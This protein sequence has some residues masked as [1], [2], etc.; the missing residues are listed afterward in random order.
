[1]S[2][3]KY[4]VATCHLGTAMGIFLSGPEDELLT[5]EEAHRSTNNDLPLFVDLLLSAQVL[6]SFRGTAKFIFH[7]TPEEYWEEEQ[8]YW[9]ENMD[10]EEY[11]EIYPDPT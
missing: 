2:E 3:R 7:C 5:L 9:K 1:M 10:P 4:C 8:A 11:K 6:K